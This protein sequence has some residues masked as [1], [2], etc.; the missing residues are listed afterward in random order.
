MDWL[1]K[2][3]PYPSEQ[4]IP[5]AYFVTHIDEIKSYRNRF[6]ALLDQ[7]EADYVRA[8]ATPSSSTDHIV[9]IIKKYVRTYAEA[10]MTQ[11]TGPADLIKFDDILEELSA[12]I[13]MYEKTIKQK[14]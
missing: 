8:G 11:V 9:R 14:I 1:K 5:Y 3:L 6:M 4:E 10:P 13:I 12:A 7:F 2:I